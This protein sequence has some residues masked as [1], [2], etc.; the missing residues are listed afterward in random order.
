LFKEKANPTT[1]EVTYDEFIAMSYRINSKKLIIFERQRKL[2]ALF[3][4]N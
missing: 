4:F 1:K 2:L 3:Y